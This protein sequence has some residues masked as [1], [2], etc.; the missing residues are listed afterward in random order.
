[1]ISG[2]YDNSVAELMNEAKKILS[3]V[4]LSTGSMMLLNSFT[5]GPPGGDVH[6][7]GTLPMRHEPTIGETSPLGEVK[8]MNGVYVVDGSS[9][10]LLTEKSHTLTIMANADRI[11]RALAL[12]LRKG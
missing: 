6:Y 11:G 7:S 3:K 4:F 5:M 2:G 9:L 1:M 8:G 12:S 10:P